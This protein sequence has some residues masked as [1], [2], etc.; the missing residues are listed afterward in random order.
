MKVGR[1]WV[2]I[3]VG[4]LAGIAVIAAAWMITSRPEPDP[5]APQGYA[6]D[7]QQPPHERPAPPPLPLLLARAD[8]DRGSRQFRFCSACHAMYEGAPHQI[9][10]NLWGIM[11]API[12]AK[13][14]FKYSHDLARRKGERWDWEN[15]NAFLAH[16]RGF[17]PGTRMTFVGILNPQNRADLLLYLNG[18]GSSLPLPPT[19]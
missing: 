10:P 13:G 5:D 15:M 19:P 9:G 6:V 17:A 1:R 7:W 4:A 12:A 11:G 2:A 14:D 16:P 18:K 3:L 8:A